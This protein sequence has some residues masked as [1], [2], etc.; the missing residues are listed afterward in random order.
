MGKTDSNFETEAEYP[1]R[2]QAW[3]LRFIRG[4]QAAI[5]KII[6][7]TK[8]MGSNIPPVICAAKI[9]TQ[10][11]FREWIGATPCLMEQD[12]PKKMT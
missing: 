4:N 2:G 10:D 6:F 12:A 8:N 3:C 9:R 5:K 1:K 7:H 11:P